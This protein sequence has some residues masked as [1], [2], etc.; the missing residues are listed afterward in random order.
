MPKGTNGGDAE[1][2][3]AI[4]FSRRISDEDRTGTVTATTAEIRAQS[5]V[6]R[7]PVLSKLNNNV[8]VV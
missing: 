1:T 8:V 5:G 3:E 7:T 4:R 6:K 2:A